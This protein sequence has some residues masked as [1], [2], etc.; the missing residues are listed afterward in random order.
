MRNSAM[1]DDKY[2]Y[3]YA[4]LVLRGN[5]LNPPEITDTLNLRPSMSFK[6]GDWRNETE[7]WKNNLWS[8]STKDQIQSTDL[9]VHL[10]WLVSQL[11]PTKKR[12][13]EILDKKDIEAEI[14]CF[15]ILPTDHEHLSLSPDLLRK[16]T[17]LNLRLNLD[18]YCP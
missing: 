12:L 17:E 15:W 9:A 3:V 2:R 5:G 7:R 11:E 4:E 13:V 16:I 1:E 18:I 10:D 8:I 14:S 6:R